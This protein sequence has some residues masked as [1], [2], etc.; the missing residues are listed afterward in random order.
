M[1]LKKLKKSNYISLK[2]QILKLSYKKKQF[3]QDLILKSTEILLNKITNIIFRYNS[4]NKRILF[5]GFPDDFNKILIGSKHLAIPE[6]MLF[7]GILLN[8]NT[9]LSTKNN[10]NRVPKNIFKLTLK[11]KNKADL[12]VTHNLTNE[13][14][15]LKETYLNTIPVIT[16]NST[17]DILN[18]KAA[19]EA[20]GNYHFCFEKKENQQ[21][22]FSLIRTLI[23]TSNKYKK[24]PS[25]NFSQGFSKKHF[26]LK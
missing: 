17:Q 25:N 11:L 19:Y 9:L 13:L 21:F 7:N 6:F 12:I 8:N 20:T 18:N 3:N 10:K 2:L 16:L 14:I 24:S 22:L 26:G 5:I 15:L 1:K 4:A 23:I